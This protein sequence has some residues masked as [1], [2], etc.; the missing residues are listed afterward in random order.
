MTI[1]RT[2]RFHSAACWPTLAPMAG[3]PLEDNFADIIGKAQR[4]LGLSDEVLAQRAGVSVADLTRTLAGGAEEALLRKL[5]RALGLGERTLVASAR[6]SWCPAPLSLPGLAQFNTPYADLRVNAYLAWNPAGKEA[7]AFDTGADCGPMLD[8]ARQH[9]LAIRLILLTHGHADH[10]ADLGRLKQAT[11]ASAFIGRQE[12]VTDAEPFSA[13]RTF[14]AGGL[15]L[16]TRATSGHS[17]GG[18][19]YVLT[20]LG[21]PVAVVGDA[22]FAGSMGGGQVSFQDALAN[23]RAHIF[24]LPDDTVV[25]PGHGPMTTVGEE[26][27]HNPFYPEFQ[28]D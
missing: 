18:I 4:G 22:L 8:F 20:G 28:T 15:S 19:T 5:A 6:Q 14:A 2:F 26:K 12:R 27:L 13:G 25:C 11:G 16:E 3:I 21:R 9:G 1:R 7:V 23:N 10:V 17:A 24:S